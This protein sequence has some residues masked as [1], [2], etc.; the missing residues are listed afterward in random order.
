METPAELRDTSFTVIR[1]TRAPTLT[2]MY[3][4]MHD[5]SICLHLQMYISASV[6]GEWVTILL[7]EE[8]E[9]SKTIA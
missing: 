8:K 3:R 6:R 4:P 7:D 9:S 5:M 1:T 2:F